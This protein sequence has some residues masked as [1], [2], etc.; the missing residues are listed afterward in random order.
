MINTVFEKPVRRIKKIIEQ[1]KMSQSPEL[2]HLSIEE[3]AIDRVL[4][5]MLCSHA[6]TIDVGAHIGSH[7]SKVTNLC[8]FGTHIAFEP[9]SRKAAWLRSKFPFAQIHSVALGAKSDQDV[10]FYINL[11][12]PGF[13][14]LRPHMNANNDKIV[15]AQVEVTTLDNVVS[16]Y[17]AKFDLLK[18]DVEGGELQ[19]LRGATGLLE[20]HRPLVLFESTLSALSAHDLKPE[21]IFDFFE[22]NDYLIFTPVRLLRNEPAMSKS[23]FILAHEYPFTSFNFF[24]R[25]RCRPFLF[26]QK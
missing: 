15:E 16:N 2:M 4:D 17:R 23:E 18:I 11:S 12:S 26:T 6:D 13:S 20:K 25:H 8:P 24:A 5:S 9:V 14:G 3:D 10:S 21:Y 19:V 1:F 7:L 22:Q